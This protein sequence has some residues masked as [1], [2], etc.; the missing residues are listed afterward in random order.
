MQEVDKSDK[1]EPAACLEGIGSDFQVDG[2]GVPQFSLSRSSVEIQEEVNAG[3]D[4][5]PAG[6]DH[7]HSIADMLKALSVELK[8]GF[9][10]SN[11]NQAEIR[12]LC[13]DLGKKIDDLAGRTAALEE[14]VGELRMVVEENKEQIRYLKEGEVGVMAKVESLENNQRFLRVP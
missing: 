4:V 12:S 2:R 1:L 11:A 3:Q 7:G 13:E 14:E 10:T 9:E 5:Q 6:E 8:G